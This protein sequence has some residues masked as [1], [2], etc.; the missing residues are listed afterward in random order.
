MAFIT[1]D[2][3][4]TFECLKS[5]GSEFLIDLIGSED[6]G[7]KQTFSKPSKYTFLVNEYIYRYGDFMGFFTKDNVSKLTGATDNQ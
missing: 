5:N 4:Q 6:E 2:I 7:L 3:E 1:E